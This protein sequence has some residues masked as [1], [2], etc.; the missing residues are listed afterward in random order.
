MV[1]LS[2][3]SSSSSSSCSLFILVALLA[4][5]AA[6]GEVT[7][8]CL[9][10][11]GGALD[12][13][14]TD[15]GD[16][17]YGDYVYPDDYGIGCE[18]Q[19]ENLPPSCLGS[20]DDPAWCEQN[21]CYV[22]PDNCDLPLKYL[23]GYFPESGLYYS[24][25]TCGS[26]GSFHEW[27]N[28][29][30]DSHSLADIADLVESYVLSIRT[31]LQTDFVELAGVTSPCEYDSA[32]NC[33]TCVYN[34]DWGG[35][36]GFTTSILVPHATEPVADKSTCLAQTARSYFLKVAGAEYQNESVFGTEYGGF[37]ED[38]VFTQW[39]AMQW[40]PTDYDPRFRPWYSTAVTNP[41][42]LILVIDVSGSMTLAGRMALAIDAA[43]A[44]L[45]TVS[46]KDKVGIITFSGAVANFIAPDYVTDDYRTTLETWIDTYLVATG[47]T[48][49]YA[50][51]VKAFELIDA[52][53][54]CSNVVL[55]L[56]DGEAV[57]QESDYDSVT[58][59]AATNNVILFT[60]ALGSGTYYPTRTDTYLHFVYLDV[61]LTMFSFFSIGSFCAALFIIISPFFFA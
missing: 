2:S 50:P 24:Y 11:D 52:D 18:L 57:F 30:D 36:V 26:E 27:F 4:R 19:D 31:N 47:S 29:D 23:S 56:T 39:P 1:R 46:W 12:P 61:F 38:G 16:L 34:S 25:Q 3:S 20:D 40:C 28:G 58:S 48:E 42:V 10:S 53:P 17:V 7:C 41:K 33:D 44:V 9:T 51:L 43:K 45:K 22:D 55:F 14:R 5:V 35:D 49:F 59:M 15:D 60:Y 8:P 37:Q 13:Y 6:D 54:G 21:F 32:C